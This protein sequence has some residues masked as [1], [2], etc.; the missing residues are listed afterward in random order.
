MAGGSWGGEADPEHTHP[1][2]PGTSQLRLCQPQVLGACLRPPQGEVP[3]QVA[4]VLVPPWEIRAWPDP[5]SCPW[6]ARACPWH[7]LGSVG[8]TLFPSGTSTARQSQRLAQPKDLQDSKKSPKCVFPAVLSSHQ[9]SEE[10]D[11]QSS[12]EGIQED[13]R[14]QKAPQKDPNGGEGWLG[15][16]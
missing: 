9:I 12:A 7:V 13:L 1:H 4:A 6:V 3:A 10:E 15:S 16:S 2:P 14:K 8:P 11:L 5:S